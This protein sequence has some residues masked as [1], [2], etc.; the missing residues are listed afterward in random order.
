METAHG[1]EPIRASFD[2]GG[3]GLAACGGRQTRL[4]HFPD[5]SELLQGG[6]GTDDPPVTSEPISLLRRTI[7][8][9][10]FEPVHP[11]FVAP[12]AS[13]VS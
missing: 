13:P 9:S 7:N 4:A 5:C 10:L 2:R 11:E 1:A 3:H 8:L 6:G 12:I